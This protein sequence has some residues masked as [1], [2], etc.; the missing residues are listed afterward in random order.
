MRPEFDQRSR[1]VDTRIGARDVERRQIGIRV[2]GRAGALE[3]ELQI[4]T[5]LLFQ[6]LQ[7][8]VIGLKK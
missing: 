2:H 1:A 5:C 6:N 8:L 3:S 4:A 7:D